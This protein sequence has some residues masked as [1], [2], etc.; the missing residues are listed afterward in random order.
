MSKPLVASAMRAW[1]GR[2]P[3]RWPGVTRPVDAPQAHAP[4]GDPDRVLVFGSGP[5][6]GWGVRTH[7]L[8]LPGQ[9]ARQ[10]SA[11]TGRGS[12]VD[13][14]ASPFLPIAAAADALQDRRLWRYDTVVVAVGS[15]D[16]VRFLP[17][18]EW[19]RKLSALL[20][21]LLSSSSA[22]TRIVVTGVPPVTGMPRFASPLAGAMDFHARRMNR[23][24]RRVC[25]SLPRLFYVG[26][27]APAPGFA[28]RPRGCAEAYEEWARLLVPEV[29]LPLPATSV[30]G[31]PSARRLRDRPDDEGR[32]LQALEALRLDRRAPFPGL[33]RIVEL[34]RMMLGTPYAAATVIDSDRQWQVAEAGVLLP[35]SLPRN[36]SFCH[37][38]IRGSGI[39]VVPDARLDDRFRAK[40]LVASDPR[41]RFYAGFPLETPDGYRIGTLSVFDSE[42]RGGE[43]AGVATLRD[44]AKLAQRELNAG[45]PGRG[46]PG[47]REPSPTVG[48]LRVSA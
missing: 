46:E 37:H 39:M 23:V 25:Q 3:S 43:P 45:R 18:D 31:S 29:T 12:D 26:L 47:G 17:L 32:R 6:V 38:T 14:L 7:E 27:P 2:L 10:L 19:E 35:E 41:I 28:D 15:D 44:L 16:A 5:A 11:A 42:P 20:R 22:S 1:H 34:S 21:L 13:L 40:P 4:G 36:V 24:T 30:I 8:A 48:A 9:L 33:L